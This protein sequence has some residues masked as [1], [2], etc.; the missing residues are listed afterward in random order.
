MPTDE[1]EKGSQAAAV[2]VNRAGKVDHKRMARKNQKQARSRT[3]SNRSVPPLR[4]EIVHQLVQDFPQLE[5]VSNGGVTSMENIKEQ[6]SKGV[7][8]VMV[9]RAAI[10][11]PALFAGV[12][13]EIFRGMGRCREGDDVCDRRCRTRGEVLERYIEYVEEEEQ[14]L[15]LTGLRPEDR[16]AVLRK[17]VS[18]PFSLFVGEPGC[19]RYQRRIRKMSS[20]FRTRPFLASDVLRAAGTEVEAAGS[21]DRDLLSA[22]PFDEV[23]IY[24]KA[25]KRAGPLQKMIA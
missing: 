18:P 13:S 16:D 7:H 20:G 23:I 2:A 4:P 21:F 5:I 9:G 22:M 19:D 1:S 11:H 6:L 17:L 25:V 3:L 10:N 24:E 14:K 8:G 15:D 12:D